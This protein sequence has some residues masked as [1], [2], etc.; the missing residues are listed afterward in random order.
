[1]PKSLIDIYN[2]GVKENDKKGFA[3]TY[4]KATKLFF[5]RLKEDTCMDLH[6][7]DVEY[8]DGYFI[9][10]HGTNSVVHF[11]V[12]EAPG[13]LFGVWWAPLAEESSKGKKRKKYRTD[14]LSCQFFFQFEKEIDKFKPSASVF[15]HE[16]EFSL[17][18]A[19][20][21]SEWID[22]YN[23][24]EFVINEP[25]LAFYKEM[26]CTDFN[27][28][29]VSRAQAKRFWTRHWKEAE[30]TEQAETANAKAMFEA[31]KQIIGEE[32]KNGTIFIRDD[33]PSCSPRYE[34]V[35]KNVILNDG[36]PLVDQAGYC[37]D[38]LSFFPKEAKKLHDKTYKECSKRAGCGGRY[39]Y[40]NPFS[41]SCLVLDPPKFKQCLK[42][43]IK[44]NEVLY[45]LKDD[46]TVYEGQV[47][48][49]FED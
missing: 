40:G 45:C 44:N 6:F 10:G 19:Y 31:Y 22:A 39:F 4:E 7:E 16:I 47:K 28:E 23:E 27:H 30:R 43:A 41:S 36:K 5:K 17:G 3:E 49:E 29:Y 18:D 13:W 46:G 1:M 14:A 35:I 25:Y 34:T 2:K 37:Y 20:T 9:F 24:F 12:K 21:N 38:L 32:I 33:G 26:H 8:L 42:D 11:H 15:S 48:R